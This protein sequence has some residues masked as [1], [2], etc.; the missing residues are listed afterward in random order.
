MNT[1]AA[2]LTPDTS[3]VTP[4]GTAWSRYGAGMPIVLLHGV[5]MNQ[6]IWAPQIQTLRRGFDVIVFDM[7]GHGSSRFDPQTRDLGDYASQLVRLLRALNI[8]RAHVVG[9][10][11][12]ALIA[13][14][15]AITHAALCRSVVVLNGVYRRTP[16]QRASVQARASELIRQG[17]PLNVQDTIH[18]WFGN[19]VPTAQRSAADLSSTLLME[20]PQQGYARAY[21]VFSRSDERHAGRLQGIALP[22]LIATGEFDPN[23]SPA[24]AR[25]MHEEIRGSQLEILPGQRHM[26]SLVAVDEV[27]AMIR[28]F[29]TH[30]A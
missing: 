21:E 13:L 15:M 8:D 20:V 25:A 6:S 1:M 18:R 29:A 9:H 28:T 5:G 4:C 2:V 10:S 19:P 17:K 16:E 30:N 24:M 22:V 26:M 14:E 11:M 3:G 23:S 7:M 27:N 12:G